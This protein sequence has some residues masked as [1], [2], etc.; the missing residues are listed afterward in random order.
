MES[1]SGF[2]RPEDNFNR[3]PNSWFEVWAWV[4]ARLDAEMSA[5]AAARGEERSE[6][7]TASERIT[8]LLK[9]MIY[10]VKHTFGVQ[11]YTAP[12]RLSA[13][14][15]RNGRP[16]YRGA[17]PDQGVG[18]NPKTIASALERLH[19]LGLIT[20][21]IDSSDPARVTK[22]VL[23]RIS[24]GK[25]GALFNAGQISFSG[26]DD[27]RANYWIQPDIFTDL[28][29]P[30]KK[31]TTILGVQYLF[32]H[33]WSWYGPDGFRDIWVGMSADEIA[34]GKYLRNADGSFARD[35]QGN[36]TRL[37]NGIGY[38][39]RN[40][41]TGMAEAVAQGLVVYR[42][43]INPVS[44]LEEREYLL[45]RQGWPSGEWQSLP[46]PQT[47]PKTE[48]DAGT[49]RPEEDKSEGKDVITRGRDVNARGKDDDA[50]GEEGASKDVNTRD[51]DDITRGKDVS[52]RGEDVNP[53]RT[54]KPTVLT[55]TRNTPPS[56][57][58]TASVSK[59]EG[60]TQA[61]GGD[62]AYSSLSWLSCPFPKTDWAIEQKR[63]FAV[64]VDMLRHLGFSK[65]TALKL[66]GPW[67]TQYEAQS[68]HFLAGWVFYHETS[69]GLDPAR[70]T[71]FIRVKLEGLE[72]PPQ[73]HGPPP[74][75]HPLVIF[76]YR[77]LGLDDGDPDAEPRLLAYPT[78]WWQETET[79]RVD[80]E[81]QRKEQETAEW[82]ERERAAEVE[83]AI[84]RAEREAEDARQK[85]LDRQRRRAAALD[86]LRVKHCVPECAADLEFLTVWD[87]IAARLG[88][89]WRLKIINASAEKTEMR[90]E[91]PV[92]ALSVA[93]FVC[94]A[95]GGVDVAL[96]KAGWGASSF[97]FPDE[98]EEAD[99]ER[100]LT[101]REIV[102]DYA[103]QAVSERRIDQLTGA[104]L[105]R[106]WPRS[107]DTD[108]GRMVFKERDVARKDKGRV[109]A[110]LAAM[111][112]PVF[113]VAVRVEW[114]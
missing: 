98:V 88:E 23:P 68:P 51:R 72:E 78:Q 12:L 7:D 105:P 45:R 66:A 39:T 40:V 31:A 109:G 85:A 14:D 79:Q 71:G 10:I 86:A 22:R 95:Q 90:F 35:G 93:R 33:S 17:A 28:I 83:A 58:Q 15:I 76:L 94:E 81:R 111:L 61:G 18:L 27:P 6:N 60:D 97:V 50:R 89:G 16:K 4:R 104:G 25:S 21:S 36:L 84:A 107:F 34:N 53:S 100:W 99:V 65:Q 102:D 101:Y 80:R 63:A 56:P 20:L 62:G 2:E 103:A 41:H 69:P 64:T 29:R 112:S 70:R 46:A 91:K 108:T 24:P 47:P 73:Q 87:D 43:R 9:C 38:T 5:E 106:L 48:A 1:F 77:R 26:F 11:N 54:Y 75:D 44:L 57:N 49:T 96:R 110:D 37:D 13:N 74:L 52:A 19:E 82:L 114:V 8:G 59:K 92:T 30:L 67:V 42:P 113:G 55:Q 32:R 3:A